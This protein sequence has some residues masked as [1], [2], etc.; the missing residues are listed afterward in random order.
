MPAETPAFLPLFGNAAQH[1][2]K[3][4]KIGSLRRRGGGRGR[5]N[6][7]LV[8]LKSAPLLGLCG[9]FLEVSGGMDF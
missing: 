8:L 7:P 6:C 3:C 2:E 9:I 5:A 1:R 4:K